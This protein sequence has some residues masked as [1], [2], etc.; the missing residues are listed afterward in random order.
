MPQVTNN[1]CQN[2]VKKITYIM[3]YK[4]PDGF[5]EPRI[6]VEFFDAYDITST[7]K[8]FFT[9]YF[10]IKYVPSTASLV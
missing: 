10:E 4:N 9:Q 5:T 3:P 6:D 1:K 8:T 2:L 7:T